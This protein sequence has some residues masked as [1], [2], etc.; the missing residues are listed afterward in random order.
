MADIVAALTELNETHVGSDWQFEPDTREDHRRQLGGIVGFRLE[1]KQISI[2]FK[3]SQNHPEANIE[4][5]IDEL[6]RS[7][8]RDGDV[9]AYLM[10]EQL[11][12]SNKKGS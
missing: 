7:N 8:Q 6:P 12:K 4:S 3:L 1:A 11:D 5:V 9:I 2:K 10:R